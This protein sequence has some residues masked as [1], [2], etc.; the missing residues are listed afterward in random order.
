MTLTQ[1]VFGY[2]DCLIK[3]QG[4]CNYLGVVKFYMD[5]LVTGRP[6]IWRSDAMFSSNHITQLIILYELCRECWSRGGRSNIQ[7]V[8]SLTRIPSTVILEEKVKR[9]ASIFIIIFQWDILEDPC[10][11]LPLYIMI[12]THRTPALSGAVITRL[13]MTCPCTCSGLVIA[14]IRYFF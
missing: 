9:Y 12:I 3:W 10:N 8:T 14:C 6:N 4:K 1:L 5:V 13:N 11:Y 7:N 2:A